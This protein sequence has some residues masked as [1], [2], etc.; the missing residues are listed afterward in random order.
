MLSVFK[1]ARLFLIGGAA[2]S[3]VACDDPFAIDDWTS[4][5]DTIQVF[6]VSRPELIGQPSA[7]DFVTRVLVRVESPTSAGSWDIALRDENGQLALA[8]AGSFQGQTSRAGLALI[9][10]TTF[11]ELS[12]AP[13]D[14]AS[15]SVTPRIVQPGQIYAVRSRRAGCGFNV[16]VRFGK[17]KIISVDQAAGT[18]RFASVVNPLCNNR[19]LIPPDVE[20][21]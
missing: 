16:G 9:T 19:D 1:L 11:E 18:V 8:P 13:G 14:T 7:Y 6:S 2:V 3:M 20:E 12:E 5:T 17:I 10:N 21:D 15:Y 4:V